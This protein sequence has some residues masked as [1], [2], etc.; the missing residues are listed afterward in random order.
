MTTVDLSW[1]LR[2]QA[3][4]GKLT[5]CERRVRIAF[6]AIGRV[7]CWQMERNA[8]DDSYLNTQVE[9]LWRNFKIAIQETL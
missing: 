9:A 7:Y 5:K 6:E 4:E 2:A 8:V 1:K 3:A